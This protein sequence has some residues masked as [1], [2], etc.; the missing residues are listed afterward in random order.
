LEDQQSKKP[1]VVVPA[2]ELPLPIPEIW[3]E[4][5]VLP[6][7]HEVK[8]V[9]QVEKAEN[10]DHRRA[11]HEG[12]DERNVE[13]GPEDVQLE[14]LKKVPWLLG[15]VIPRS[16]LGSRIGKPKASLLSEESLL[17][18][19]K[20]KQEKVGGEEEW[21]LRGVETQDLLYFGT[22]IRPR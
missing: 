16:G 12:E 4:E 13:K 22:P 14:A 7:A 6:L 5:H 21:V 20:E 2:K 19:S 15:K 1:E 18:N 10:V 9:D 8:R 11:G 17:Q 3:F